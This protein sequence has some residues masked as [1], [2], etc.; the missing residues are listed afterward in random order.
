MEKRKICF[1]ASLIVTV[2]VVTLLVTGSSLLTITLDKNNSL[3]LGNL[4]TWA[5]MVSL[6][7]TIY[8]GIGEMR[9]PTGPLNKILSGILKLVILLAVLWFPISFLLAG[10]L[11]FS[12]SEK[13][14]FRGSQQAMKWF[15]GLSYGIGL[16]AL[17]SLGIFGISFIFKKIKS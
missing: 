1:I 9:N 3:P 13:E 17:L 8:W 11:T 15:W 16:G 7:L 5:G 10:N 4:I 14:S 12:F 6:P 2:I